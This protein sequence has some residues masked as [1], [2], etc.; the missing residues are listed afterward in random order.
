MI[1]EEEENKK[2]LHIVFF[3]TLR[4]EINFLSYIIKINNQ[5]TI[6]MRISVSLKLIHLTS[7]SIN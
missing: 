2:E 4:T 5:L 7:I 1:S 6:S 3:L